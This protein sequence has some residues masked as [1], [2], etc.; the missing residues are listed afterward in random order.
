MLDMYEIN[1]ASRRQGKTYT[2]I[3]M[4]KIAVENGQSFDI[5]CIDQ[6]T[7]LI[8]CRQYLRGCLFELLGTWGIRPHAIRKISK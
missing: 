8:L 1:L 7:T 2:A 6:I 4:A 3:M 5:L